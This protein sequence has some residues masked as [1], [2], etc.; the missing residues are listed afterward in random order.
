MFGPPCR[1]RADKAIERSSPATKG[2]D[3]PIGVEPCPA[4]DDRIVVANS[5]G[6]MSLGA[7]DG[8]IR[9]TDTQ[10]LHYRHGFAAGRRF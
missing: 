1:R 4:T 3:V 5:A 2:E 9:R 10:T 6:V 7:V 8:S